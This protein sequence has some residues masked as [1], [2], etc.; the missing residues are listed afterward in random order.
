V[1]T[2]KPWC[3][4]ERHLSVSNLWLSLGGTPIEREKFG[5]VPLILT[6]GFK[7]GYISFVDLFHENEIIARTIGALNAWFSLGRPVPQYTNMSILGG[8]GSHI[9]F[10]TPFLVNEK[11][12]VTMMRRA[13]LVVNMSDYDTCQQWIHGRIKCGPG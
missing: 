9:G 5:W 10:Q 13:R 7:G 11:D 6:I 8:Q 1:P 4:K 2:W 3:R 12:D